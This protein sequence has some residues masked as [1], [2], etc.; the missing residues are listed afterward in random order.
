M[1]L[2][3]ALGLGAVVSSLAMLAG[4]SSG[5]D[6]T[7]DGDQDLIQGT[8]A[9]GSEFDAVGLLVSQGND[10]TTSLCT[11]TLIA[12]NVVLTAKHCAMR[13]PSQE[14]SPTNVQNGRVL[15]LIGQNGQ[16]PTAGAQAIEA[17]PS[18]LYRGG[19]TSLGSDVALYTLQQP[20]QGIAPLQVA[21]LP[22]GEAD[23]NTPFLAVGYGRQD[24]AG[25]KGTRKKGQVTLRMVKGS[26]GPLAFPTADDYI[27]FIQQNVGHTFTEPQKAAL[28]QQYMTPLSDS[29]EVYAGGAPGDPQVCHGDSGGPLLKKDAAGKWVVHGVASTTMAESNNLCKLGGMYAVFGASTRNLIASKV[30]DHCGVGDD[31][32]LACGLASEQTSCSILS[33]PP[34]ANGLEP[35]PASPYV[36]CLAAECCAEVSAC[37]GDQGCAALSQCFNDCSSAGGDAA[38]QQTCNR[39]CYAAN[40]GSFEKY[41]GFQTCGRKS[42]ASSNSR[43]DAATTDGP[44]AGQD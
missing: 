7:H 42:C 6:I 24:A 41:L 23:V 37:F 26:P 16:H 40:A 35:T 13:N 28:R 27:A 11:G 12:P 10:G 17:T 22:P 31:G 21:A 3:V 38:A 32:V 5:D 34:S 4:C 20:I 43:G 15:F 9:V 18:F 33:G 36:A 30:G 44:S 19:Y 1:K 29:Y 8:D 14:G 25:H 39:A 2:R